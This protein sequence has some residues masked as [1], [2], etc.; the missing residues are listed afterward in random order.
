M[1]KAKPAKTEPKSPRNRNKGVR[2]VRVADIED[3]PL[4]F[5]KHPNEQ[6]AA[7]A[8]VV[9]EIGWYGYPDVYVTEAGAIRLIDGQLRKE[10]LIAQYGPDAT[11][12]VNVTDF[13]ESEASKALATHDPLSAMAE[14][15][16]ATLDLLLRSVETGSASLQE[17]FSAVADDAGLYKTSEGSPSASS[18]QVI[19]HEQAVQLRPK[20]E[21]IVVVCDSEEDHEFIKTFLNLQTVRRGGYKPGSAFDATSLERVVPAS[22]MRSAVNAC[23]S[24]E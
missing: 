2:T 13:N 11:V 4:N 3:N 10:H 9:S 20:R 8:G 24:A 19:Q 22:R 21:Y 7:F 6:K 14:S 15:D 1:T 12:E 5:R 23:R 16:A 18:C 17:L